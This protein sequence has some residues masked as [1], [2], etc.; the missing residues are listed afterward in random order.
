MAEL[1]IEALRGRSLL[2]CD[3][4]YML[5]MSL[6]RM[7]ERA[8][9][10]VIGPAPNVGSALALVASNDRIDGAI[11]DINLRGER[12]YPIADAL[13]KRGVPFVF[14]TGYDRS[15]IPGAYNDVPRLEKPL[16]TRELVRALGEMIEGR[17]SG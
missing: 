5:A 2:V 3:D 11:L 6:V 1:A 16:N 8:G 9:A 14:A 7:L 4:E 12:A 10:K 15:A 17:E 13:R